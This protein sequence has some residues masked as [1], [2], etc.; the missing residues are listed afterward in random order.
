MCLRDKPWARE[1][2][3]NPKERNDANTTAALLDIVGLALAKEEVPDP[4]ELP[5]VYSSSWMDMVSILKRQLEA[6]GQILGVGT[7]AHCRYP[8][9]RAIVYHHRHHHCRHRHCIGDE[10]ARYIAATCCF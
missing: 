7:A 4:K 2:R 10:V 5:G 9:A 6:A 8:G 3:N 1:I